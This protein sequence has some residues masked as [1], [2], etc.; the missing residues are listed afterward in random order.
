MWRKQ[1]GLI[2][3]ELIESGINRLENI[4]QREMKQSWIGDII[5]RRFLAISTVCVRE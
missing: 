1:E 3:F 5:A 2:L 4:F